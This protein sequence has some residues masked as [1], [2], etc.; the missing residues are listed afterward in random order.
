[1][2]A[3]FKEAARAAHFKGAANKTTARA[4]YVK[5]ASNWINKLRY[6]LRFRPTVRNYPVDFNNKVCINSYICIIHI[7]TM[8]SSFVGSHLY[9]V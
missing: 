2:V 6:T 4:A 1:M 7:D 3:Y 8:T 5:G 9:T